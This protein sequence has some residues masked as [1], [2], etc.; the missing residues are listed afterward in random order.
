MIESSNAERHTTL[1]SRNINPS[2][3]VRINSTGAGPAAYGG[4]CERNVREYYSI[5]PS[6]RDDGRGT[7]IDLERL[8]V[9]GLARV[10]LGG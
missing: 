5:L 10:R 1:K 8:I 7:K 9:N 4:D 6:K 3:A 2:C